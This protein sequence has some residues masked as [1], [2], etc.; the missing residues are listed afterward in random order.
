M[1]KR[2]AFY[3][4]SVLSVSLAVPAIADNYGHNTAA[5][6]DAPVT[7][8]TDN[9]G[10]KGFELYN[11]GIFWWSNGGKCGG[12]FPHWAHIRLKGHMGAPTRTPAYDCKI[13]EGYTNNVVR[14]GVCLYF[15]K[16]GRLH[17]KPPASGKDGPEYLIHNSPS[18]PTPDSPVV[19]E[20]VDGQLYFMVFNLSDKSNKLYTMP[21]DGSQPAQQI[22]NMGKTGSPVIKMKYYRYRGT[23]GTFETA[24]FV[25]YE[26][27]VLTRCMLEPAGRERTISDKHFT[28]FTLSSLFSP[29]GINYFLLATEGTWT[30]DLSSGPGALWSIGLTT[31]GSTRNYTASGRNQVLSV[32]SGGLFTTFIVVGRVVCGDLFC[33]FSDFTIYRGNGSNWEPLVTDEGSLYNLRVDDQTLYYIWYSNHGQWKI[34]SIPK[35]AEPVQIDFEAI[36]LEVTQAGQRLSNDIHLIADRRTFVRGYARCVLDNTGGIARRPGALLNGFFKN[37]RPLPGSPINPEG[38]TIVPLNPELIDLRN[39]LSSSFL[40]QLP[41]SWTQEGEII[42]TMIVNPYNAIP[43]TGNA[44]NL[45]S[46]TVKFNM[47]YRTCLAFVSVKADSGDVYRP[48]EFGSHFQLVLNRAESLLPIPGFWTRYV[49]GVTL[50]NGA[51]PFIFPHKDN[52]DAKGDTQALAQLN[53][54][55]FW[56]SYVGDWGEDCHPDNIFVVGMVHGT[57]RWKWGGL[58]CGKSQ[59]A[60]FPPVS[61]SNYFWAQPR[62]AQIVA[63]E[64]GHNYGRGHIDCGGPGE[65][66]DVPPFDPCNLGPLGDWTEY[67]GFDPIYRKV[68]QPDV[69]RDLMTYGRNQWTSGF[70][71]E[72]IYSK[73]PSWT[74]SLSLQDLPKY[75]VSSGQPVLYLNGIIYPDEQ[76]AHL[77]P[78]YLFD[79]QRCTALMEI[80]PEIRPCPEQTNGRKTPEY[81]VCFRD[82]S[83]SILSMQNLDVY[84]IWDDDDRKEFY[85]GQPIAFPTG[86]ASVEIIDDYG[87][88]AERP[89]TSHAPSIYVTA[90]YLDPSLKTLDISWSAFDNDQTESLVY[91]VLYSS[92]NGSSW[93]P[94]LMDYTLQQARIDTKY[95]PGGSQARFA[96]IATDGINT[97]VAISPLFAVPYNKPVPRIDGIVENQCLK[98]GQITNLMGMALDAEDG[99]IPDER[100]SWHLHGKTSYTGTGSLFTLKNLSPGPYTVTLRA[101]DSDG[102]VQEISL[103]F[104]VLPIAVPESAHPKFDGIC[105]DPAWDNAEWIYFSLADGSVAEAGL[106]YADNTLYACFSQLI[107][108]QSSSSPMMVGIRI[109]PNASMDPNAQPD[110]RGFFVDEEGLT[111]QAVGNGSAMPFTDQPV[112]GFDA[113]VSITGSRW[114]AE[115]KIDKSLIGGWDHLAGM[116]ID[117]RPV[118]G[119]A[120]HHVWPPAAQGNN[121]SSWAEMYF[122]IPPGCGN[123]PPIAF[124]GSDYS[125]IIVKSR[126]LYLDGTG[127]YDPDDDIISYQWFQTGGPEVTLIDADS[128]CPH[129][130]ADRVWSVTDLTFTLYVSDPYVTGEPAQVTVT[131]LPVKTIVDDFGVK[132]DLPLQGRPGEKFFVNATLVN[133]GSMRTDVPFFCILDVYGMLF[134][135]PSWIQYPEG[136]DCEFID[137]PA[138]FT[139]KTIIPEFIWPRDA[140][141]PVYNLYFYAAFLTPDLSAIDGFWDAVSWGYGP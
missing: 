110:D 7:V 18:L 133:P 58:A 16:Q 139:L 63:H 93:T 40:F 35:G 129:F 84:N 140:V 56:C 134:F 138:G 73:V 5:A 99:S 64:L 141:G 123:R 97:S 94:L 47:K 85:F 1:L 121:P 109:D 62:S 83:G 131:L 54:H 91:T 20:L 29:S 137:V 108:A 57:T 41:D 102:M 2:L 76:Y 13:I 68:I 51:D 105:S 43:E 17:C 122:G 115:M 78:A 15:F 26:N 112:T 10:I 71:W 111:Y 39:D 128:A 95:L 86:T 46:T 8:A 25:L 30:P 59:L 34:M 77:Q 119:S 3:I 70:T 19:M 135:F 52:P 79:D 37:G 127:S 67:W 21:I 42:L 88:I 100:L 50:M 107:K 116:M 74:S 136:I 101:E 27:G 44:P 87:V 69:A 28:D 124:A 81:A 96:V 113:V 49:G 55:E 92:D 31:A 103:N 6:L 33:D 61:G 11:N 48:Y 80:W 82:A 22:P 117:H 120:S 126:P 45:I 32:V 132:L 114:S 23:S 75:G 38:S 90:P 98:F 9:N 104:S 24:L 65:P 14:D 118:S 12:E 4:L 72:A 60:K 125:E 36:G 106:M 66:F 130:M 89:V 53:S